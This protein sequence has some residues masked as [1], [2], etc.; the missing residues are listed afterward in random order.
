MG[1]TGRTWKVRS[2]IGFEL[3]FKIACLTLG[4]PFFR[5]MIKLC[6]KAAG[7]SYLTKKT[8]Q[9]FCLH[10]LTIV[11]FVV[12]LAIVSFFVFFEV[13]AV[14]L[15]VEHKRRREPITVLSL[16]L[17][18]MKQTL[19]QFGKGKKGLRR[20]MF[21]LLFVAVVNLPVFGF[22]IW[23]IRG[24]GATIKVVIS[25]P[26]ILFF[27]FVGISL[28][29]LYSVK[30]RYGT[31]VKAMLKCMIV[32]YVSEI[33]IYLIIAAIYIAILLSAAPEEVSGV[34]LL[35][36]F[37]RFHLIL[38]I[39]FASVNTVFLEFFCGGF[40]VGQ[41]AEAEGKRRYKKT[42]YRKKSRIA[43]W[44]AVSFLL[45]IALTET[46][47]FFRSGAV[48][49]SE[50]L[51]TVG[52]TA[53]RGA[54]ANA[55]ENTMAAIRQAIYEAADYAEIDIRLTAD[56]VP[57]LLHDA[58][59]FRTTRVY[60]R[61]E[62]VTYEELSEYDAGSSYS[63]AFAGEPVPTLAAVLA[64]FG[65]QIGFNIELKDEKSRALTE[66]VVELIEEYHLEESCV[67]TSASYEQLEWVKEKNP[68]IKTGYIISLVY[69]DFYEREAVDFFSIKSV[70]VTEAMVE[71]IHAL[72]KEIHVWTVN[73]EQE[74]RR[75]KAMGV[76]YLITDRP[77]YARE[78]VYESELSRSVES[79]LRLLTAR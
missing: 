50:T 44:A 58:A 21:S 8:I 71:K 48:L 31:L 9:S 57:V 25:R 33:L 76:D 61:L 39:L 78:I 49:L 2:L 66:M 15:A 29:L 46:I 23:G 37:E 40:L 30:K 7:Y 45:C 75:M 12:A 6:M 68:D 24:T 56:G 27:V 4:F 41:S 32:L 52:I 70:Y 14:G 79:W 5:G 42:D 16:F 26:V 17:D 36:T 63:K 65:G 51:D 53:H 22:C 55:P 73:R 43:F 64:E 35:R 38:C 59:L 11:F 72:G 54:S 67:I 77:E 47:F 10:P 19:A 60:K 74:L 1:K 69:G 18:G 13:Y 3:L 20:M 28:L 34:L 62:D